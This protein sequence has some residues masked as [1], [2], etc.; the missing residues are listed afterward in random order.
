MKIYLKNVII[1]ASSI[2]TTSFIATLSPNSLYHSLRIFCSEGLNVVHISNR[3]EELIS[4]ENTCSDHSYSLLKGSAW[5]Y[6]KRVVKIAKLKCEHCPIG[7]NC[8][9]NI[10]A[11]SNYW[12]F[13]DKNNSITMIRCPNGYCCTKNKACQEINSCNVR[14]TGTLCGSYENGSAEAIF[15]TTCVPEDQCLGNIVLLYD[16][17]VATFYTVF[18]AVYKDVQKKITDI[19]KKAYKLFIKTC[20]KRN[21]EDLNIPSES[22]EKSNLKV[23]LSTSSCTNGQS[24]N[25]RKKP[26]NNNSESKHITDKDNDS[27]KYIQILFYYVQ[28]ASLF[29]MTVPTGSYQDQNSSPQDEGIIIKIL[30]FSPEIATVV[31]KEINETCFA[32][33]PTSVS[34][35]LSHIFF[36]YYCIIIILL[37]HLLVN[38]TSRFVR[39]S[40]SFWSKVR[41]RLVQAFFLA[42]LFCYQKLLIAA[43]RIVK[44]VEIKDEK[45]LR[46]QGDVFCYNW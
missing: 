24:N 44:C 45:I 7:A 13:K 43:F 38:I 14:R 10:K 25:G 32:Y 21:P 18:L 16:T 8:I 11:L 22:V 36:G 29:R 41:S 35:V 37:L 33:T 28:D 5:M 26:I 2:P 15:S 4:C 23:S 31:Y 42:L 6:N 34:K 20:C 39:K 27:T 12:G 40:T 3:D 19:L 30:S 1:N 46:I 9:S 17:L